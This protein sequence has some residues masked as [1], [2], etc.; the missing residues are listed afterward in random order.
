MVRRVK[1]YGV[2]GIKRDY[3]IDIISAQ[4]HQPFRPLRRHH[5]RRGRL[6]VQHDGVLGRVRH[7]TGQV[8]IDRDL[9]DTFGERAM[10]CA[11]LKIQNVFLA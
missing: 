10:L 2:L 1:N 8:G 9:A 6:R 3:K 4:C 11:S 7:I 5:L